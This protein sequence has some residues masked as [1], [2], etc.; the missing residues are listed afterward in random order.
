LKKY[1]KTGQNIVGNCYIDPLE[2]RSNAKIQAYD[3]SK[4]LAN[5]L[6][7]MTIL[8][9]TLADS[10]AIQNKEFSRAQLRINY[11]QNYTNDFTDFYVWLKKEG[12]IVWISNMNS[13]ASQKYNNFDLS[14]RP[15]YVVPKSTSTAYY[16]SL[17]LS[18]LGSEY[19]NN[20]LTKIGDFNGVVV[21]AIGIDTL[22]NL[23]KSQLFPQFNSIIG[24]LD[25]NG[26]ILY[27]DNPSYIANTFSVFIYLI[28]R[29][30]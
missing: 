15:Y 23:L 6:E 21:T 5:R 4:I 19:S 20:N 30:I 16:S 2:S 12:T 13:S 22:G 10:P 1:W 29:L 17:I 9:Q 25:N 8:L 24:I 28:F 3:L 11:R 14:Y 18:K 7:S 26:V 27:S